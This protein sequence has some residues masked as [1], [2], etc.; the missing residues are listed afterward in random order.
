[1]ATST[2]SD[3]RA[4]LSARQV[5]QA[6][7]VELAGKTRAA[8]CLAVPALPD[9]A[10]ISVVGR[11]HILSCN[12][13]T[14]ST[15]QE[16]FNCAPFN[17][18]AW[19]P[20]HVDMLAPQTGDVEGYTLDLLRA[21]TLYPLLAIFHGLSFPLR[22][23]NATS[24]ERTVPPKR[25]SAEP[26]RL[27]LD[28]L[29]DDMA[30]F[31]VRY[32]HR[33]HQIPGVKICSKHGTA[34][35]YKCPYCECIFGRRH[36]L[37]LTPWQR[38]TCKRYV[39]ESTSTVHEP[40]PME[41]AYVQFA[42]SLLLLASKDTVAP[43]TL[44]ECYRD[45]ARSI[46]CEWGINKVNRTRL[47]NEIEAFYGQTFLSS[48]D[49][50]YRHDRLSEWLKM[51]NESSIAEPPLGRHLLLAHFLFRDASR[52]LASLDSLNKR[53]SNGTER[54][55]IKR[56]K[57]KPWNTRIAGKPSVKQRVASMTRYLIDSAH[58]IP[59]CSIE[60]LWKSNY[61]TMKR[62][63]SLDAGVVDVLRKK[64]RT[65]QAKP[66]ATSKVRRLSPKDGERAK[67]VQ[68][69]AAVLYA[70]TGKPE[71][72]TINRLAKDLSWNPSCLDRIAF[73]A[74]LKALEECS[75]SNWHL[76]ARRILWAKLCHKRASVAS[77][78]HLSG[79]EHHRAVVLMIFFDDVDI[80]VKYNESS[81]TEILSTRGIQRDWAGPCP[82]REFPLAGRRFYGNA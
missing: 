21:H 26:I 45:R 37:V 80:S 69:T 28:C 19:V 58:D 59:G 20:P 64:L 54:P 39:F 23:T 25:L 32:I 71:K 42:E 60:D 56:M 5:S 38:C 41:L 14:A 61:G 29:R 49:A 81:I 18:A 30:T 24:D 1:M 62:L 65:L 73:P 2:S 40:E 16:L 70:S 6:N 47:Q 55:Q 4:H 13:T 77:L 15:F 35:L 75:E 51:L 34:L 57:T 12:R 48:T 53:C 17:L 9:E 11:H 27:C 74:T 50:A 79:V 52:F 33:S 67:M 46:G 78:K 68:A 63:V 10:L 72:V 3:S 43:S 7:S 44:V 22:S 76:Y 66:A 82:D 36:D 8:H 31:G